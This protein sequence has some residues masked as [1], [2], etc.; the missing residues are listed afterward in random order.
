M[1]QEKTLLI[2]EYN[3]PMNLIIF[4]NHFWAYILEIEL[5]KFNEKRD[6]KF[7]YIL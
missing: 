7:S 6:F 4:F 5:I 3:G 2:E 1:D